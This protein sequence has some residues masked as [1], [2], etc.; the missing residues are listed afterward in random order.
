MSPAIVKLLV[1]ANRLHVKLCCLSYSEVFE[2]EMKEVNETLSVLSFRVQ[3]T[4]C[5][6]LYTI[7][8]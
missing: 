7:A 2:A 8:C 1:E 5:T 6:T 4:F 3:Q